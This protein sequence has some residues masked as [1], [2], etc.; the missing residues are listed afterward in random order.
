V[1]VAS[2]NRDRGV[3]ETDRASLLCEHH[4]PFTDTWPAA[5]TV[6]EGVAVE[7]PADPPAPPSTLFPTPRAAKVDRTSRRAAL[8]SH[9]RSGPSLGQAVEIAAGTLPPE[10]DSWEELPPSWSPPLLPTPES[11]DASGGR[12][13][14]EMGGTRPSGAKRAITLGT[15]VRHQLLPTPTGRESKGGHTPTERP[16]RPDTGRARPASDGNLTD[17]LQL[18]PTPSAQDSAGSRNATCYR[19]PDAGKHNTGTTLTDWLYLHE[20]YVQPGEVLPGGVRS[21]EDHLLPTPTRR[22]Y[23]GGNSRATPETVRQ[24]RGDGGTSSLPDVTHLFATGAYM[25]EPPPPDGDG[26]EG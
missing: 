14:S 10:F 26:G 15:A 5:G 17:A 19:G 13:S 21:E 9:S 18:L 11:S 24:A 22:D 8:E 3:W 7:L 2:W 1:R 23:K 20:G 4:E 12:V 6:T 16:A 25:T